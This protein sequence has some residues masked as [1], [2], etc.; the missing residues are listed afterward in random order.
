MGAVAE[1][2]ILERLQ[3]D[4]RQRLL[5]DMDEMDNTIKYLKEYN[6]RQKYGNMPWLKDTLQLCRDRKDWLMKKYKTEF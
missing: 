4:F 3:E 1:D 2:N 6:A 5:D